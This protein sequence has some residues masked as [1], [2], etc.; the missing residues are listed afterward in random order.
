MTIRVEGPGRDH[1][2]QELRNLGA[3]SDIA[4]GLSTVGLPIG[5]TEDIHIVVP[6]PWARGGA[7]TYVL[8]FQYW[9][10]GI[11]SQWIIK[12]CVGYTPGTTI[13]ALISQYVDRRAWFREANVPRLLFSGKGC[14]VEEYIPFAAQDVLAG[15]ENAQRLYAQLLDICEDVIH[16][17]F[18]PISLLAD[19]RSRGN[20]I[21]LVDFGADLGP[22]GLLTISASENELV[23][24]LCADVERIWGDRIMPGDFS[25]DLADRVR[26]VRNDL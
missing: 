13:D 11:E 17:G 16:G 21:V 3:T 24:T 12:A 18:R 9:V 14:I 15:T 7:E 1:L 6:T 10:S 23:H 19:A 25:A 26:K 5:P 20:D 2:I 22:P 8:P 4:A